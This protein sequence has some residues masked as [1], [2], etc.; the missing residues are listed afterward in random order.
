MDDPDRELA[1]AV[2]E[3]AETLESLRTELREPPRGPLG[4]PRP[5]TPGEF[6]RFTERF[7]IPATISLLEASIRTLELLAAAIRIAEGRPL[8]GESTVRREATAVGADR[9]AAASRRTLTAL[10]D[11]LSELQTAAGGSDVENPEL[12]RLL[13]DAR[14]LREEVDDRLAD[15]T[16]EG[17]ARDATAG[18]PEPVDI[19]VESGEDDSRADPDA[20]SEE[21]GVGVDVDRELESIKREFA[22]S[23]SED[24]DDGADRTDAEPT[25]EE[26]TTDEDFDVGSGEEPDGVDDADGD[27]AD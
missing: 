9:L 12:Q 16:A 13:A 5:P 22:E 8:E 20:A 17:P 2:E 15:A 18:D 4:L 21:G 7:A 6:L 24:P 19:E 23:A 26:Q 27:D 3:L 11:A 10:D 14:A 1:A 25:D